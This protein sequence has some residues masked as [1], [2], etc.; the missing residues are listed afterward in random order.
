MLLELARLLFLLT[1]GHMLQGLITR[2]Q[3]TEWALLRGLLRFSVVTTLGAWVIGFMQSDCHIAYVCQHVAHLGSIEGRL[4]I[5]WA[6]AAG[7]NLIF[8][9]GVSESA[10][11]ALGLLPP[12]ALSCP[13]LGRAILPHLI[14]LAL[15]VLWHSNPFEHYW[16]FP[17]GSG[18]ELNPLLQHQALSY[19]PPL[20]LLGTA[21]FF[22]LVVFESFEQIS[23]S[24]INPH[25]RKRWI[26]TSLGIL[27]CGIVAGSHW[28]YHV[29]GWGGWWFWDPIETIS[30]ITW[31]GGL[32]LLHH[33]GP[34]TSY[35]RWN[36]AT[37]WATIVTGLVLVRGGGLISVHSFVHESPSLLLLSFFF[38]S[39][40]GVFWGWYFRPQGAPASKAGGLVAT[41]AVLL[42]GLLFPVL[43]VLLGGQAAH[44][45][46]SYYESTVGLCLL[47]FLIVENFSAPFGLAYLIS[48]LFI[49]QSL[50]LVWLALLLTDELLRPYSSLARKLS[51]TLF[52]LAFGVIA[53]APHFEKQ[54]FLPLHVGETAAF[55]GGSIRYVGQTPHIEQEH[56]KWEHEFIISYQG[57][58]LRCI[59]SQV[60]YPSWEQ[61]LTPISYATTW[62]GEDFGVSIVPGQMGVR[63]FYRP[64]V[65]WVWTLLTVLSLSF[66]SRSALWN[67][68]IKE[69]NQCNTRRFLSPSSLLGLFMLKSHRGTRLPT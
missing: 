18:F 69:L 6:G 38:W 60:R 1:L 23:G 48:E 44:L 17:P 41:T 22:G 11:L 40:L 7:A 2:W 27:G 61:E 24:T 19:H 33:F 68:T 43:L 42:S 30:L 26:Y 34:A 56:E 10:F 47:F 62:R 58:Q 25:L 16:P 49:P 20:L 21:S 4:G 54:Y 46:G 29:L 13:K 52:L 3:R 28:A 31:T 64:L 65:R 66:L 32:A 35:A 57:Q 5:L 39:L 12:E 9:W 37:L 14:F 15:I 50:T 45:S 51:H 63:L 59:A 53:I 67:M 55:D 36:A 8:F